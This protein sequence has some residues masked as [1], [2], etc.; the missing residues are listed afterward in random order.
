[1]RM[2]L[3]CLLV[4]LIVWVG[5]RTEAG[6]DKTDT[7]STLDTDRY[8]LPQDARYVLYDVNRGEGFNLRRDVHMRIAIAVKKL[9]EKGVNAILVLPPWGGLY[10]WRDQKTGVRWSDLFDVPSINSFVPS[11]EF[12]EFLEVVPSPVIDR[13]VYLQQFSEGWNGEYVMKSEKRPCLDGDQFYEKEDGLWKGWF[14]GKEDVRARDLECVSF[15]GDADTFSDLLAKN[16]STFQSIFVDRAE[17]VLHAEYGGVEYWRAR[18][19]M[20]YSKQ[21]ETRAEQFITEEMKEEI[22]AQPLTER[23]Q[24]EQATRASKGGAYVC[25]HWRRRDFVTSYGKTLPS[26]KGAAE[27][28]TELA[29][30]YGVKKAFVA[31]DAPKEEIEKLRKQLKIT[32]YTFTPGPEEK[33]I[34]GASAIVEQIICSW[35][36]AFTGSHVST[37]SYRIQEDR[38]IRGFPVETTFRRMCADDVRSF[39]CEQPAKWKIVY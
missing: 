7:V 3:W 6:E 12:E 37:F 27:Q 33:L 22:D 25:A 29:K 23:W 26:I 11:I 38:E 30:E 17:T 19:S 31:T 35:A 34:D 14:Y 24:D 13:I 1:S 4:T 28:I 5:S 8:S 10:H 36:R 18:R 16:Y 20:R 21:L 32:L 2:S 9:R 39:P 15:Q